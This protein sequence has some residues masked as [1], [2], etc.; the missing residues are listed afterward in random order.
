MAINV[1]GQGYFGKRQA[2]RFHPLALAQFS[3]ASTEDIQ[4]SYAFP[5]C[6]IAPLQVADETT[7]QQEYQ[8]TANIQ[9]LDELDIDEW[10]FGQKSA[11]QSNITVPKIT[12]VT[13]PL[14]SPYTATVTGLTVDQAIEATIL[15]ANAPGKVYLTQIASAGSPTDGQFDVTADTITFNAA[16]AGKTVAIWYFEE[17]ASITAIGGT[18][19][20]VE[21]GT[22]EMVGR[23]TTTR[24]NTQ[25]LWMPRVR[26]NGGFTLDGSADNA[27]RTMTALID[28]DRG[29]TLPYLKWSV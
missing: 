29:F 11:T 15:T 4:K 21:V 25:F 14:V 10:V 3:F 26:Y 16:Q 7:K 6:D 8:I 2:G 1:T 20:F 13:V 23:L 28:P 9:S 17:E 27:E 24:T 22:F 19:G 12:C 18:A 5:E